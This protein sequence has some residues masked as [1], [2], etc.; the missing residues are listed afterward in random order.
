MLRKII[1]IQQFSGKM[2]SM[3]VHLCLICLR[4]IWQIAMSRLTH[5]VSGGSR[6]LAH[7]WGWWLHPRRG[8][9]IGI[10]WHGG[11]THVGHGWWE[12][13][14]STMTTRAPM[15]VVEVSVLRRARVHPGRSAL[16]RWRERQQSSHKELNSTDTSPFINTFLLRIFMNLF[17]IS[18]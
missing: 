3:T 1:Q 5:W 6:S 16:H 7:R 18:F 11:S 9:P 2:S 15:H 10:R 14:V 4:V 12:V 8:H 17:K 13:V